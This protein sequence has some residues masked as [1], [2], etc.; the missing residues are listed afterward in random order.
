MAN[1]TRAIGLIAAVGALALL[2][3]GPAAAAA[4]ERPRDA[5]SAPQARARS[6]GDKD[7]RAIVGEKTM[8]QMP[9]W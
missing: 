9:T 3:G 6:G 5:D 4:G 1:A 2:L 8:I 7:S